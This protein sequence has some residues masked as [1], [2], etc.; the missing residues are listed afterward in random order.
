MSGLRR[1]VRRSITKFAVTQKKPRFGAVFFDASMSGLEY[2]IAQVTGERQGAE[3]Q[4]DEK[5]EEKVIFASADDLIFK[6]PSFFQGA[7]KRLEKDLDGA[8]RFIGRH[9]DGE[10]LYYEA[11]R[12]DIDYANSM[13]EAGDVSGLRRTLPASSVSR[14]E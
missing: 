8:Y 14:D 12:R 5:G 1:C 2:R 11:A 13:A 6:A 10:N 4:R 3:R 9:F 7:H